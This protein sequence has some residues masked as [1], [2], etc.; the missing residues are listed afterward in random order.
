M[1]PSMRGEQKLLFVENHLYRKKK[2][3]GQK[4]RYDCYISTCLAKMIV[5]GTTCHTPI[6]AC[7]HNH[8]IQLAM[9]NEL[10]FK[11]RVRKAVKHSNRPVKDIFNEERAK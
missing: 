9:K 5:E 1:V 7:P 3:E 4:I 10:E 8:S 11:Y 2:K 6:N